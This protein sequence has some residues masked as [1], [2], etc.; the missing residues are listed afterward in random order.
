MLAEKNG[1]TGG[2]RN[3]GD[4]EDDQGGSRDTGDDREEQMLLKTIYQKGTELQ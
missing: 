1:V 2:G 3:V 4:A